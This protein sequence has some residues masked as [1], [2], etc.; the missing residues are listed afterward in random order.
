MIPTLFI[1]LLNSGDPILHVFCLCGG[2]VFCL[3]E[4]FIAVLG[5]SEP[6]IREASSLE[7]DLT[8]VVNLTWSWCRLSDKGYE[9]LRH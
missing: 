2:D 4:K 6:R 3:V 9:Q 5:S 8:K 1:L 7:V